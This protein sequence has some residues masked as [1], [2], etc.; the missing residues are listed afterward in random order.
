MDDC[1][2]FDQI[3][4]V[5]THK[6][7]IRLAERSD[8]AGGRADTTERAIPD[9]WR[10]LGRGFRVVQPFG[11]RQGEQW[12]TFGRA[13]RRS[14]PWISTAPI[15]GTVRRAQPHPPPQQL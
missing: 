3:Q 5:H 8:P 2:H 4:N 10:G 14:I 11:R 9:D 13:M 6:E 12:A 1:T 15:A 7:E